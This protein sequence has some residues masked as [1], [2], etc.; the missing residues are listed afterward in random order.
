MNERQLRGLAKCAM[1]S[2]PI[3]HAGLP[4]F[5]TVTVE[6]HGVDRRAVNR[7]VGLANML[8]NAALALVMGPN[9]E[10]TTSLGGPATIA[11]CETCALKSPLM[12][13]AFAS[14]EEESNDH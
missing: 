7:Q 6:R 9:E 2:Q 12:I 10:M 3:L 4:L 1:C 11:V 14:M 13:A 8:G 5:W